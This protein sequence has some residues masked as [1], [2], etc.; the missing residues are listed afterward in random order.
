MWTSIII[1][2]PAVVFLMEGHSICC[3]SFFS[4]LV[5]LQLLQLFKHPNVYICRKQTR[6]EY[7]SSN[8]R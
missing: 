3:Y 4:F 6:T 1:L 5:G 7:G 2:M 8:P